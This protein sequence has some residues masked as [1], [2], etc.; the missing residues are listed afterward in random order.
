MLKYDGSDWQGKWHNNGN[1]QFAGWN[2]NKGDQFI[3]GDFDQDGRDEILA[4]AQNGWAKLLKYDGSDWQGKWI[5]W[6]QTIHLAY[7]NDIYIGL[8][9]W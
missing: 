9:L 4:I 5:R 6:W 7:E 2:M 1:R 8:I 3:A